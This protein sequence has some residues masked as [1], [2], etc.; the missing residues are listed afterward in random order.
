MPWFVIGILL[1]GAVC[2]LLALIFAYVDRPQI[3]KSKILKP[4]ETPWLVMLF[5]V[6]FV[7]VGFIAFWS[8]VQGYARSRPSPFQCLETKAT[9]GPGVCLYTYAPQESAWSKFLCRVMG[10][11]NAY[12]AQV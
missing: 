7:S 9:V 10:V 6:L 12:P 1:F 3:A 8:V 11:C 4:L 2:A 5:I